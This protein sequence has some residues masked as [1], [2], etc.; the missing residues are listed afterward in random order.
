[1]RYLIHGSILR[2]EIFDLIA[3]AIVAGYFFTV[4]Y[5]LFG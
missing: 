1:L 4:I 3:A 2:R 5:A